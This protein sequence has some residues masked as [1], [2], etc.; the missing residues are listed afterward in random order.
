MLFV[1]YALVNTLKAFYQCDANNDCKLDNY[2]QNDSLA[3]FSRN[4]CESQLLLKYNILE[5]GR[6]Y[7]NSKKKPHDT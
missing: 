5:V 7:R 2:S 6:I 3:E 1:L 4:Y